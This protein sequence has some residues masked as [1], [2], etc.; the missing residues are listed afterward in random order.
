MR[1]LGSLKSHDHSIETNPKMVL[2]IDSIFAV[3]VIGIIVTINILIIL[4]LGFNPILVLS[5]V[6]LGGIA[7]WL[8][9]NIVK[10]IINIKKQNKKE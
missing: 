9:T 7:I 2:V 3:I 1:F 4:E 10:C 5:W 6:L 8:I